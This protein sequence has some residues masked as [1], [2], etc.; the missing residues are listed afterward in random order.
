MTM[1]NLPHQMAWWRDQY[2]ERGPGW[3]RQRFAGLI[4]QENRNSYVC[5]DERDKIF[6]HVGICQRTELAAWDYSRPFEE[7]YVHFWSE[8][9]HRVK[10]VNFLTIVEDVSARKMRSMSSCDGKRVVAEL[11]SWV[12][13]LRCSLDP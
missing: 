8:I 7:L 3:M 1:R 6:A 9:M 4:L 11:P 13:D 10:E 5:W 2:L 12:P